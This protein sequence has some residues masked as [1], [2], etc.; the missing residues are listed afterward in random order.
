MRSVGTSGGIVL[1][2]TCGIILGEK[3]IHFIVMFGFLWC[4]QYMFLLNWA[5]FNLV[6]PRVA[7]AHMRSFLHLT[8]LHLWRSNVLDLVN[9]YIALLCLI[10]AEI[11]T[12]GICNSDTRQ[13]ALTRRR[14]AHE[15]ACSKSKTQHA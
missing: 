4:S 10:A 13:E 9:F 15:L 2:V 8:Y 11:R 1:A 3:G 5:H 12:S 6:A 7:A 14:V